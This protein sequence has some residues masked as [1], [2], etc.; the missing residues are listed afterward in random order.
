MKFITNTLID[1]VKNLNAAADIYNQDKKDKMNGFKARNY[2]K[3]ASHIAELKFEITNINQINGIMPTL[4]RNGNIYNLI[5]QVITKGYSE[6]VDQR[7]KDP[8]V[9]AKE[10][11]CNVW[12]IGPATADALIKKGLLSIDDLRK[13]ET[14]GKIKLEKGQSI[15]L[16]RYEDLLL[17]MPREE[18]EEIYRV[19]MEEAQKIKP[20]IEAQVCGSYRRGKK[21]CGD[22]DILF[23]PPESNEDM[24][25]SDFLSQL[26]KKLDESGYLTDHLQL[27]GG[28]RYAANSFGR[29]SKYKSEKNYNN[30]I[31]SQDE[32]KN[33]LSSSS[34]PK[35]IATY[36]GIIKLKGDDRKHRRIDF[37]VYPRKCL[38]FALLYFTG[39][40]QFNRSMRYCAIQKN[41]HLSD[42]ALVF[43]DVRQENIKTEEDIFNA[44][45]IPYY[46]PH[47]RNTWM[48]EEHMPWSKIVEVENDDEDDNESDYDDDNDEDVCLV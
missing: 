7:H 13:A 10:L 39:S 48:K 33:G 1:I 20:G 44:L 2:S 45:G 35:C 4:N 18:V 23:V 28:S 21:D 19:V 47:E 27:P 15:G 37:K 6:L 29:K 31:N 3:A 32:I 9:I 43:S 26:Y 38:P 42:N 34:V 24:N 11:F 41:G 30:N 5:K 25:L 46:E 14:E 16:K 8:E 40:G 22:I 17:R 12:G 36:M